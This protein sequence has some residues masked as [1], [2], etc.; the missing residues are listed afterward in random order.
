MFLT[1]G[2]SQPI[3]RDAGPGRTHFGRLCK[4]RRWR[5]CRPR[6]AGHGATLLLTGCMLRL[7]ALSLHLNDDGGDMDISANWKIGLRE[8]RQIG[9][10]GGSLERTNQRFFLS[11]ARK[12]AEA[13]ASARCAY[14]PKNCSCAAA[15]LVS[16]NRRNSLESTRAGSRKLGLHESR[17]LPSRKISEIRLFQTLSGWLQIESR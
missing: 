16:I 11:G 2:R 5:L 9:K 10:R 8:A 12:A 1:A 4:Q 6:L 14:V 15:S 3:L 7:T 17:G 13:L